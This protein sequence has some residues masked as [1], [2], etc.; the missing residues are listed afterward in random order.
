MGNC[1]NCCRDRKEVEKYIRHNLEH[2]SDTY[3]RGKRKKSE[4]KL[5]TNSLYCFGSGAAAIG[6]T[7]TTFATG[8]L[9]GVISIPPTAV[10]VVECLASYNRT[11]CAKIRLQIISDILTKR[12]KQ[13]VLYLDTHSNIQIQEAIPLYSGMNITMPSLETDTLLYNH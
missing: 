3:L 13:N 1:N 4:Y 9:G 12:E 5:K 2:R 6:G 11:Q 10:S 7:I 8:G